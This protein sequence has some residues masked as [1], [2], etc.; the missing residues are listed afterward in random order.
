MEI[1]AQRHRRALRRRRRCCEGVDLVMRARRDGRPDRTERLGQDH[2]AA[3]P[4]QSA[5]ARRRA[6]CAMPGRTAAEVGARELAR[7]IAYLAQGGD[8]HWPMRVEALVALG[9]LPHRRRVPGPRCGRPRRRSSRRWWR[10]TSSHLRDRTMGQVSGGERMRIL[11][12]RALAV[13]AELLL[14]DEPIAALDP[15]HQL[16]VMELLRATA[17]RPRCD[18]RAARSGAGGALLRSSHPAGR[19]RHPGRGD[20]GR[21]AHRR[22]HRARLWRRGGARRARRRAVPVAVGAKSGFRSHDRADPGFQSK[23]NPCARR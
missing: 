7:R 21:G 13:E 18:R 10:P 16:Q 11:L 9:R 6:R 23:V 15:L 20:A 14:A 8:V 3:D 22:P 5:R 12:A 2:A 19:R 1:E 17:R 4:R